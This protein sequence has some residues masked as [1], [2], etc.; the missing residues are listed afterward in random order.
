MTKLTVQHQ[1]THRNLGLPCERGQFFALQRRIWS[2]G[3]PFLWWTAAASSPAPAILRRL[4]PWRR[5]RWF[6][7]S[8]RPLIE[9]E[10][11][12]RR[13]RLGFWGWGLGENFEAR[14]KGESFGRFGRER[15]RGSKFL[16]DSWFCGPWFVHIDETQVWAGPWKP[17]VLLLGL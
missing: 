16:I 11:G 7:V 8:V 15:E 2:C 17:E 1:E 9:V 13:V 14:E 3:A 5:A 6:L 12:F 4:R 10:L